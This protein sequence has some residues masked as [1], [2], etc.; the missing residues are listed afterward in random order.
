MGTHGLEVEVEMETGNRKDGR[1]CIGDMQSCLR[2]K[3]GGSVNQVGA[4]WEVAELSPEGRQ[5]GC[6]WKWPSRQKGGEKEYMYAFTSSP[7]MN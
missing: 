3:E 1:C 7:S 4:G 6:G 2:R 5:V